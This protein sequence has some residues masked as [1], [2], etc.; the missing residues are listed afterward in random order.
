MPRLRQPPRFSGKVRGRD[1]RRAAGPAEGGNRTEGVLQSA[2]SRGCPC[3]G[4]AHRAKLP[5]GVCHA[6]LHKKQAPHWRMPKQSR[7]AVVEALSKPGTWRV[8]HAAPVPAA[9]LSGKVRG[10]DVRHAAG[11]A[12]GGNRTKGVLQRAESRGCPCSG[13]AH[14]AKLPKG[15][16]HACLHKKQVPHWRMPKQSHR[17]RARGGARGGR[18]CAHT[19]ARTKRAKNFL[20]APLTMCIY[21]VIL[22]ISYIYAFRS[23]LWTLSFKTQAASP[24][25]S[26]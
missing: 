5:K 6:C 15:V 11:P 20:P 7:R 9:A 22:C 17:S 18:F 3:T 23:T 25:M 14:R 13:P 12:G 10:R 19:P 4:P 26:R 16:C 2:E 8:P 24:F 21:G 1:V